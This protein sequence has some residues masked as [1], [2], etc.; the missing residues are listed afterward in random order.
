MNLPRFFVL[1]TLTGIGTLPAQTTKT[2]VS[3]KAY[4]T[5]EGSGNNVFPF[6]TGNPYWS[7]QQVHADL[8]ITV[9][10]I[11]G[12]AWRRD[13]Q[14]TYSFKAFS[15]DV[16]LEMATSGVPPGGVTKDFA[17]NMGSDRT[18]VV[19]GSVGAQNFLT[20]NWPATTHTTSPAPFAYKLPFTVPFVYKKKPVIW[21]VKIMNRPL[22]GGGGFDFVNDSALG[23]VKWAMN[24]KTLFTTSYGKGCSPSNQTWPALASLTGTK[25]GNTWKLLFTGTQLKR[26]SSALLLL[27]YRKDKWGTLPLPFILPGGTCRI[28]LAPILFWGPA[29][30]NASG[31]VTIQQKIPDQPIFKGVPLYCQ[32]MALDQ[33]L[34]FGV[35]LSS[36]VQ[37]QF[38]GWTG[39]WPA[40]AEYAWPLQ[41]LVTQFSYR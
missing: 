33:G 23:R 21:E 8:P 2:Y 4:A 11:Q 37:F 9:G 15:F 22:A 26:N 40:T 18:A 34:P 41:G 39:K 3:P 5:V 14:A 25:S 19:F 16:K 30:T 12:L 31:N 6:G 17:K 36:G 28:L 13:G 38:P 29:L 20:V 1:L 35:V 24:M 27:G 10:L 7:Y 32:W